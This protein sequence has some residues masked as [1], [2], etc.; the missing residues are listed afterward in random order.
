VLVAESLA[1]P[2]RRVR[3]ARPGS[4]PIIITIDSFL[5]L[6]AGP[7]ENFSDVRPGLGEK[8]NKLENRESDKN[9]TK[10]RTK[11]VEERR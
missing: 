5:F 2:N 6:V 3:W 1:L 8:R 11:A 4:K 7:Q 10:R 9:T